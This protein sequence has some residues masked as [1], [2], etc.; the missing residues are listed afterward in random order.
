MLTKVWMNDCDLERIKALSLKAFDKDDID[1]TIVPSTLN[2]VLSIY[3]KEHKDC[4]Y[5]TV[6]RATTYIC[7]LPTPIYDRIMDDVTSELEM[8]M[9]GR[10][11]EDKLNAIHDAMDSRLCDLENLIDI[12][13]YLK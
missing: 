12:K 2:A 4:Y 3:E 5:H 7:E 11:L 13:K 8:L 1:E 10:P 9:I 6:D